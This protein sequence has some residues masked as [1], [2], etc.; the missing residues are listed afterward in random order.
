MIRILN[1]QPMN[2][3]RL[4]YRTSFR[5]PIKKVLIFGLVTGI[6]LLVNGQKQDEE[7]NL[8]KQVIV[9]SDYQPTL[10]D[11]N[12]I[13]ILPKIED[14]LQ[15]DP[16]IDYFVNAVELPT[17]YNPRPIKAARMLGVP[18]T[19]LYPYYLRVGM[20]NYTTPSISLYANSLRSKETTWS[21]QADHE[22][23]W[24]KVKLEN[25]TKVPAHYHD[26]YLNLNAKRIFDNT[27]VSG[28][29]KLNNNNYLLYGTSPSGDT[30]PE[31][32]DIRQNLLNPHAHIRYQSLNLDDTTKLNFDARLQYD[33]Y[34]DY[35]G[36]QQNIM[37]FDAEIDQYIGENQLGIQGGYE[38]VQRL[39][40]SLHT[41]IINIRPF[42][43]RYGNEWIVHA[44]LDAFAHTRN[45]NTNIHYYP[46]AYLEYI[47][48]NHYCNPF[49]GVDGK[50]ETNH[51]M[52][53][54]QE[55]HWITPGTE[56]EDT[57][58]QLTFYA[59][60]KG[61]LSSKTA[62]QLRYTYAIV[63][64]QYFFINDYN[65]ALKNSFTVVYS[66]MDYTGFSGEV[67]YHPGENLRLYG[68]GNWHKYRLFQ[69]DM[70]AW[71]KPN[72]D[73][74]V[75][76][77][78]TLQDKFIVN[79]QLVGTGNQVAKPEEED[80]DPVQLDPYL[81]FNLGIEYRY[82][83]VLSAFIQLNNLTASNYQRLYHYP[84]QR[85][86]AILGVSYAFR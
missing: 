52:K 9:V 23:S 8:S 40:D 26:T 47:V 70:P 43:S 19:R 37:A 5:M 45:K 21:V 76:A 4:N 83:R 14:S 39:H 32:G 30:I 33:F 85:F 35:Y 38:Y 53:I 58:H 49:I 68:Q 48:G 17:T 3:T 62:F 11:A 72:W 55:N 25:Q 84:M 13:N 59:G 61:K 81:N 60:V 69:Q 7:E 12:K 20:G 6:P 78:Y 42:L 44:G 82:T 1:L 24:G 34:K 54:L 27:Q 79:A 67:S 63:E 75:S 50:L 74:S 28:N 46:V 77:Q 18:L 15:I 80:L 56:I 73:F 86:R 10:A 16:S 31:N 22:S 71:H 41:G 36:Y 29:I 2:T 64:N 57:D 66:D 51:Y 65:T